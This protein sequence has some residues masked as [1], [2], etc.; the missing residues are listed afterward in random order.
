MSTGPTPTTDPT[1]GPSLP[2]RLYD[3][4]NYAAD[5]QGPGWITFAGAMML[6]IGALNVIYGIAAIDNSKFFV[7]EAAFVIGDLNTW[8]W[9]LVVLGAV[10]F[11]AAF[12]IFAGHRLSRWI[13]IGTAAGNG[14]LQLVFLP[15]FP[16]L[17][18][19]IFGVD[20]L[21]LYAL[22]AF[23]GQRASTSG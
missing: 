14:I 23:G 5:E 10:Q 11:L 4:P 7:R 17:A 20:M 21:I 15:S 16:V 22:I 12:G 9:F 18:I 6:I 8:G 19:T 13:G 1:P 2:P 3:D